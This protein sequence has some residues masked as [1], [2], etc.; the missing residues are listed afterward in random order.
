VLGK[1]NQQCVNLKPVTW[2]I[3]EYRHCDESAVADEEAIPFG[4]AAQKGITSVSL[5]LR[6]D[7]EF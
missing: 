4:W 7:G 2:N 5:L 6:N 1:N 3:E